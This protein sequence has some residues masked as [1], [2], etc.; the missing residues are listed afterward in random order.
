MILSILDFIG[1]LKMR[2]ATESA[3]LA[4]PQARLIPFDIWWDYEF[5]NKTLSEGLLPIMQAGDDEL[6]S[7]AQ[8]MCYD[9]SNE[10]F[11]AWIAIAVSHPHLSPDA[12]INLCHQLSMSNQDAF[13][14][15]SALGRLDVLR[16]LEE[17]APNELYE[18]IGADNYHT[19]RFAA[20]NGR[21]DVLR[22]LARVSHLA[23]S[24]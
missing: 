5:F 13:Q 8:K 18:M 12:L 24:G 20:Q 6:A 9:S 21:L 22:Y 17:K 7:L 23:H 2:F 11:C 3:R 1:A 14:A 15:A 10:M 4:H 16:Y 19:F